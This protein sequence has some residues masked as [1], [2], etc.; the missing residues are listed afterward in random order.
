[1]SLPHRQQAVLDRMDRTLESADPQL[2]SM[3]A[4]FTR[5]TG[6]APFPPVEVI[7]TRPVRYLV[8]ALVLILAISFLAFGVSSLSG[9]CSAAHSR[10]ASSITTSTGKH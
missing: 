10:C 2:R 4:A 6:G 1:M 5:R 9:G 7:R 3:Y 8:L